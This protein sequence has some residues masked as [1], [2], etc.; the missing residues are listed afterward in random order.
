MKRFVLTLL[1]FTILPVSTASG[2]W[3]WADPQ[4]KV[5]KV[6]P[7]CNFKVCKTLAKIQT[8]QNHRARTR[9]YHERKQNEW[10]TWTRLYIP[11]CTWYGESGE[12]PEYARSRY[13]ILN[14]QGSGARGKFQFMPGTYAS[15]AKYHDW[16]PLDQEIAARREYW[17]NGITP[18]SN[19][20][21]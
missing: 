8:R 9:H 14:S 17:K 7:V 12:G 5:Q 16:S 10:N 20:T 3:R 11:D 21:G 1:I 15:V 4:F 13:T 19:C 2:D 6:K 18:W